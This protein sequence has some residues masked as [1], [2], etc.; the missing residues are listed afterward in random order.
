MAETVFNEGSIDGTD[1]RIESDDNANM[2]F[3]D[4][5]DDR[6]GIGTATPKETFE[7]A[8]HIANWRLYSTSGV[9]NGALAFNS[10]YSGSAWAHDDNSKVSMNMYL[11]D[12][13]DSL[14]FSVR[15]GGATAGAGSTHMAIMS[16]GKIGIG[17]TSPVG[18]LDISQGGY[19]AGTQAI[20]FG[21]D[22]GDNTSR[23]NS[24]T[25]YGVITG[26]HYTT[27]EEK[28]EL[29][30]YYSS[31]SATSLVIGGA[32]NSAYNAPTEIGLRI[33]SGT[34]VTSDNAVSILVINGSG[35]TIKE[36]YPLYAGRG[37]T[38]GGRILAGHYGQANGDFLAVL[39]THYSSG[40]FIV[41]YGVEGKEGANG[42]VS[43]QD[44]FNGVRTAMQQDT[45]GIK[46][47]T[48][49]ATQA[50][51]G[52]D[53]TMT[54]RM[55]ISSAGVVGIGDDTA[56][57]KLTVVTDHASGYVGS[58]HN[59]G[60]NANRYGLRI[61]AGTDDGSGTNYHVSCMDGD[62]DLEGALRVSSGTFALYDNS[63][64]RLKDNIRD[65][66][67]NGTDIVNSMKVRDF[68]WKK[69]GLT[70]TAGFVA[71]ELKE[72]FEPASPDSEDDLYE[73]KPKMMAISRDRL[74]PVLVK[75]IQELSAE[76]E[77]LKKKNVMRFG[78]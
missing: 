25:K 36:G 75:S 22:T 59:D 48:S 46:F 23:T 15:A 13:R 45:D 49:A 28:I 56:T 37:A 12:T 9:S 10:Y 2:F 76:V 68:E 66:K 31:S 43:T 55:R 61:S 26:E 21:A 40:G 58:F 70:E 38:S 6:I 69:S 8:G 47:L 63:D 19:T 18:R 16:D 64:R 52:T 73:D 72:S 14:E 71:Q 54:E 57:M 51:P 62:N 29:I 67:I 24:T 7:V 35:A 33:A 20:N 3:V 41:G 1:F 32:G 44:A 39:S 4:G 60:N 53:I 65:T 34:T 50:S 11:S 27:S 77:D 30:T 78:N 42:Y 74:V 17:T 5:A